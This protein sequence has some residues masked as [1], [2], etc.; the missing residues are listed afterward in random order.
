MRYDDG[1][2]VR[3]KRRLQMK[4]DEQLTLDGWLSPEAREKKRHDVRHLTPA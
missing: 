4:T 2:I 3:R 1:L